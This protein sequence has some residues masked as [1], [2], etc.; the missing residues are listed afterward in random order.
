M[1]A[2]KGAFGIVF[3]RLLERR[4][5]G[6]EEG[7]GASLVPGAATTL[8]VA[9]L[10]AAVTVPELS[11]FAAAVLVVTLCSCWSMLRGFLEARDLTMRAVDDAFFEPLPVPRRTLAAARG[12]VLLVALLVDVLNVALPFAVMLGVVDGAGAGLLALLGA[13]LAALFGLAV[14]L[15]LR[16]LLAA[17]LG[18]DRLAV[19]EG[20]LRLVAGVLL[21][22]AA[23]FARDLDL[24]AL[25][26]RPFS[27]LPPI[28]FATPL[29]T[30]VDRAEWLALPVAAA[31]ALLLAAL[32]FALEGRHGSRPRRSR[33]TPSRGGTW[34]ARAF[35]SRRERAGFQFA[36]ALI[37]RDRTFRARAFP[38]FS[39]PFAAALIAALAEDDPAA[40]PMAL[41]GAIVYLVLARTFFAF[42]ESEGGPRLLE[43]FPAA[44]GRAFRR[45][46]E[47]AFALA[48]AVPVYA[49]MAFAVVA[50][51]LLRGDFDAAFA[52]L[53]QCLLA[54]T[55]AVLILTA[56]RLRSPLVPF[57]IPD[58]GLYSTDV[59]G[60]AF[61]ALLAA[62]V[63]AL[64][65]T[66]L[67]T[68]PA[69]AALALAVMASM[70]VAIQ[71]MERRW[72]RE[73]GRANDAERS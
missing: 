3:R 24:E 36:W 53:A 27:L 29:R 46:G 62:T 37:A 22:V 18:G 48:L 42:S 70:I 12:A 57:A 10:L 68:R 1:N 19:L 5:L 41:Y 69:A 44:S 11:S 15:L 47:L 25:A 39:F 31:V 71:T 8:G 32:S 14:A 56:A 2:R 9:T 17:S 45:G 60:S 51:A 49:A 40:L 72:E 59:S 28:V 50:L 52:A 26:Q 30:V 61:A 34:I 43:L 55:A 7:G 13:F 21:F 23:V 35:A 65:L 64:F 33:A 73:S 20:P 4:L 63:F 58:H 66:P 54:L 38:L 67:A 16:A 6:V